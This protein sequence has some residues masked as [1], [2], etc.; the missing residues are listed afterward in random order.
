MSEKLAANRHKGDRGGWLRMT[1]PWLRRRVDVGLRE[2]DRAIRRYR[3]YPTDENAAAVTSE[4]AD[5]ANFLMMLADKCAGLHP[6][7]MRLVR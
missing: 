3:R 6:R 2:L 4:A 7:V 5:A 1:R